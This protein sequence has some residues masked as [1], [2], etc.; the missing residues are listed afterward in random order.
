MS[1]NKLETELIFKANKKKGI[2][3]FDTQ[4][5]PTKECF[6]LLGQEGIDFMVNKIRNMV[7]VRIEMFGNAKPEY[8]G[9]HEQQ[10]FAHLPS[11]S[12]ISVSDWKY[13]SPKYAK[14]N[15][16]SPELIDE[17]HF[18]IEIQSIGRYNKKRLKRF[19]EGYG[20]E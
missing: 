2:S 20:L 18:T 1:I 8:A 10:A 11:L 9:M 19:S 15:L 5:C 7:K 14:K 13:C 3:F 4:P 17:K 6:E 16:Q 12:V